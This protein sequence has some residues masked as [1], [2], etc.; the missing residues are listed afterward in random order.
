MAVNC[1]PTSRGEIKASEMTIRE[2]ALLDIFCAFIVQGKVPGTKGTLEKAQEATAY[3][4][5]TIDPNLNK[6]KT[7]LSR[8]DEQEQKNS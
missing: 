4:L 1:G 5:Q 8:E 3:Y 7:I 6:P 2:K